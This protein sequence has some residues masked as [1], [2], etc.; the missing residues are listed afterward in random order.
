MDVILRDVREIVV[1]DVLDVLHVQAAGHRRQGGDGAVRADHDALDEGTGTL[2]RAHRGGEVGHVV[3]RI[4]EPE[5][6]DA[7]LGGE[8]DEGLDDVVGEVAVGDQHLPAEGGHERR[9]RGGG[10]QRPQPLEG[11]LPE[12][13]ELSLEG[14]AAKDLEGGEAAGV[15]E[16]R[17]PDGVALAQ[18]AQ[19]EGLLPVAKRGLDQPQTR[20]VRPIVWGMRVR[21]DRD[22]QP[23]HGDR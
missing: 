16:L 22:E 15:E 9:P 4:E 17:R 7:G 21:R 8:P 23:V 10:G 12:E 1:D 5:D 14:G 11:V 3:E 6:A 13:P 2:G 18:A 20:H 19:H